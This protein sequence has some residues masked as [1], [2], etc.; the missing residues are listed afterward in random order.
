MDTAWPD[1]VC[2]CS[3]LT[4]DG[5]PFEFSFASTGQEIRYATEFA[6]PEAPETSRLDAAL[7]LFRRLGSPVR[8]VEAIAHW[9]RVQ[10]AGSLRYGAFIGGRHSNISDRYKLYVEVPE[11]CS[12]PMM[13]AIDN[14]RAV[15]LMIGYD[16][17]SR[18]TEVYYRST[19]VTREDLTALASHIGLDNRCTQLLHLI[20]SVWQRP[21]HD[22]LPGAE[23][24]FSVSASPA[25]GGTFAVF[26]YASTLFA[27]DRVIRRRILDLAANNPWSFTHYE[28]LTRRLEEFQPATLAH[29]MLTYAISDVGPAS[30][31]VGIR[32]VL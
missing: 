7:D 10:S 17:V 22:A 18:R 3:T 19:R 4:G 14:H 26:N 24:G 25:G 13:P 30:L 15:P 27:T 21:I 28:L 20:E 11:R 23:I 16:P 2:Q 6:A 1:I 5:F 12:I 8:D 9:R 31:H 32:P 29:T